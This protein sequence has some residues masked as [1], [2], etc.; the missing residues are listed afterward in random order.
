[1]SNRVVF[2]GK[3]I[4]ISEKSTTPGYTI[5]KITFK[6]IHWYRGKI[7]VPIT[8]LGIIDNT[9]QTDCSGM[10]NFSVKK[11]EEW[12][13]FGQVNDGI[14]NPDHWNSEIIINGKL[15]PSAMKKLQ[16]IHQ[17]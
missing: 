5:Q 10:L 7:D 11:G 14:V 1:M 4:S 17:K 16:H 13:I 2:Y 6:A 8:A 12:L 15:P 3:V 9:H